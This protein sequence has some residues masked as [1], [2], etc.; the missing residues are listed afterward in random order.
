LAQFDKVAIDSVKGNDAAKQDWVVGLHERDYGN[1]VAPLQHHPRRQAAIRDQWP[2]DRVVAIQLSKT[3]AVPAATSDAQDSPWDTTGSAITIENAMLNAGYVQV[4]PRIPASAKV[5]GATLTLTPQ[6]NATEAND[7]IA[8]L[9]LLPLYTADL[10]ADASGLS[11]VATVYPNMGVWVADT[12]VTVDISD[13]LTAW[14]ARSNFRRSDYLTIKLQ[15]LFDTPG[16]STGDGVFHAYDGDPTKAAQ[17]TITYT[18]SRKLALIEAVR[19]LVMNSATFQSAVGVS[20]ADDADDFVHSYATP[21]EITLPCA[22]IHE[23][24]DPEILSTAI[25]FDQL[26][27]RARV[28]CW[29]RPRPPK[30]TTTDPRRTTASCSTCRSTGI[31]WWPTKSRYWVARPGF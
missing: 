8:G 18:L 22:L 28:T 1:G 31:R 26:R 6:A 9:S 23:L 14:M 4:R 7:L 27:G 17:V 5:V 29:R 13:L 19:E 20:A 30:S 25:G 21:L 11:H 3:R 16:N 24:D 12:P 10:T 15:N 2:G